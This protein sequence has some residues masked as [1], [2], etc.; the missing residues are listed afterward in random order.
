MDTTIE[1]NRPKIVAG[2]PCY[3]EEKFISEVVREAIDYVDLV[4]VVDDGS[5][6]NTSQAAKAAGAIV[7]SHKQNRGAGA[8]T[9]KCFEEA[10][11]SHADILVTLDGDSQHL[12]EDIMTLVDPILNGE[13]DLVIGS[14]FLGENGNM[15]R[16]RKFGIKVINRLFNI[17][18]KVKVS[19]TQSCFGAHSGRL[20]DAMLI[21]RS[22]LG[23]E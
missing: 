6:D 2:I 17:G 19:D 8:A 9:K 22:K 16:Y 7:T 13:V 21:C 15:P 3:N 5:N 18:S 10:K 12:P 4:I 14:R 20:L 11:A 23:E 1:L